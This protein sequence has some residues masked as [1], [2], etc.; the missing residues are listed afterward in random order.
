[1]SPAKAPSSAVMDVVR[2]ETGRGGRGGG[3]A[4]EPPWIGEH[5][6]EEEGEEGWVW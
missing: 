3:E 1:M 4:W 5:A 2:E 6:K